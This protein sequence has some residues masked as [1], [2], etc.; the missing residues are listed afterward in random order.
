MAKKRT[1]ADNAQRQADELEKK[2]DT[3]PE[4]TPK[5]GTPREDVSQATARIVKQTTE[6]L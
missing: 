4:Q 5:K 6:N 3:R 2:A 1:K